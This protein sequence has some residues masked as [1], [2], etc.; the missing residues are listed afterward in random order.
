MLNQCDQVVIYGANGWMGR[1]AIDY[2]SSFPLTH[3][4]NKLLLIGSKTSSL[5]I[6]NIIFEV[7]G[8][9]DGYSLIRENAMFFNAAFLRREHLNTMSSSNYITK[10]EEISSVAKNAIVNKKLFSF[11]NLSSGAA[12]E[13]DNQD[14][15]KRNDEYSKLKKKFELEYSHFCNETST[16]L[17]NC[18]IFSLS[19]KHL[20]DFENLA[21][22]SFIRQAKLNNRIEVKSPVTRRTYLDATELA[23]A[24]F[25]IASRGE[26]AQFDS[27]GVLVTLLN[28]A[29]QVAKTVGGEGCQVVA[30]NQKSADYF[31][32]YE[33]FNKLVLAAGLPLSGME[34]QIS[35]TTEAFES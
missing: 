10:N 9:I 2:I 33:A 14:P 34:K 28:L 24:L 13:L 4:K 5:V 22:S 16:P 29:K 19:G 20:N 31:G 23:K 17:T 25:M 27:G 7:E 21:L 3:D 32:D 1:S 18:R 12:R 30:G 26:C 6:N 11:I 35:N 15:L 8:P